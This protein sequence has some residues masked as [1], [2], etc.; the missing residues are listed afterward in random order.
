MLTSVENVN[1]YH[2]FVHTEVV[3]APDKDTAKPQLPFAT[4]TLQTWKL[5]EAT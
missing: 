1:N 4:D 5:K 2:R 3:A